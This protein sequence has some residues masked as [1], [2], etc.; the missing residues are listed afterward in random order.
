MT[1]KHNFDD[2]AERLMNIN[3]GVLE[4]LSKR[5]SRGY[6][7][8]PVTE[9]ERNCYK[10]IADLDHVGG[11]VQGSLTSKRYMRNEICPNILLGCSFV[12]HHICTCGQ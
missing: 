9:E 5:L 12:V 3:V 7:V 8:K 1:E 4:D 11:H 10:L 2:I 6:R